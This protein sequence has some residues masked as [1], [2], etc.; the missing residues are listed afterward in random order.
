MYW[1]RMNSFMKHGFTHQTLCRNKEH[2]DWVA[3]GYRIVKDPDTDEDVQQLISAET[4]KYAHI[5]SKSNLKTKELKALPDMREFQLDDPNIHLV[6]L[7]MK[8]VL[9]ITM[10]ENID[11]YDARTA[12]SFQFNDR[13]AEL[14]ERM[15][16]ID[17]LSADDI[18][19][20]A[21][22][23]KAASDYGVVES[24]NWQ[25]KTCGAHHKDE[26]NVDAHSFFPSAA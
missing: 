7:R 16:Y 6:P 8:D 3:R 18:A 11:R 10:N 12:A 14:Q 1:L 2:H 22:W 23:E 15:D 20:I 17:N 13:K 26:L 25:C 4:L 19:T 21:R 24:V 5:I 9:T